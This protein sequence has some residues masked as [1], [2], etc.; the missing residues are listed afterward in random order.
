M[1]GLRQLCDEFEAE[2][3]YCKANGVHI[4]DT[5]LEAFLNALDLD[6]NG[7]LDQEETVG[8]FM[9]RKL[10]GSQKMKD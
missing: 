2:N 3:E 4:S 10:I 8:I 1:H 7:A 9:N 6:G 5:M